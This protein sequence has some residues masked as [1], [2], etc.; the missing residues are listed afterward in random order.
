MLFS[1]IPAALAWT[2]ANTPVVICDEEEPEPE[3]ETTA[4]MYTAAAESMLGLSGTELFAEYGIKYGFE[5]CVWFT[6]LCAYKTDLCSSSTDKTY[7]VFPPFGQYTWSDCGWAATGVTY[8]VNWFAKNDKG[9]VYKFMPDA[10]IQADDSVFEATPDSVTPEL[11]DLLYFD[12][13]KDKGDSLWDHVAI[14]KSFDP[15]SDEITFIGGNQGDEEE[16][17]DRHVTEKVMPRTSNEYA[18]LMRIDFSAFR[19]EENLITEPVNAYYSVTSDTGVKLREGYG[20]TF[21]ILDTIAFEAEVF[22]YEKTTDTVDGYVWGRTEYNGQEGWYAMQYSVK[23]A[24]AFFVTFLDID[25]TLLDQMFV[26]EGSAATAPEP[27]EHEGYDF[28]GWDTDFSCIT[29]DTVVRAVY[30]ESILCG[31]VNSDGEINTGDAVQVLKL[32]AG[33]TEFSDE[34]M[35]AGDTNHDEQVN[36]ADAVHILK[37]AAGMIDSFCTAR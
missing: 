33:M 24:D 31:D 11:G 6:T 29:E 8:Q 1:F 23:T 36:T 13:D 37:F 14:V 16:P 34:Q 21:P 12:W 4:E 5:W 7:N 25:D 10:R 3:K 30:R 22:V 32:A 28:T 2:G 27:P 35:L 17:L 18:G 15:E 26:K 19:E 9:T 20:L